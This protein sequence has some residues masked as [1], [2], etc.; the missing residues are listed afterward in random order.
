MLIC[1]IPPFT[2]WSVTKGKKSAEGRAGQETGQTW[3]PNPEERLKAY[4]FMDDPLPETHVGPATESW[5]G[6]R[7]LL[8]S[9]VSSRLPSRLLPSSDAISI[10]V[11]FK[12]CALG[13]GDDSSREYS[14]CCL[15]TSVSSWRVSQVTCSEIRTDGLVVP[16]VFLGASGDTLMSVSF[17]GPSVSGVVPCLLPS[18]VVVLV[19]TEFLVFHIQTPCVVLNML[20]D[21]GD[22]PSGVGTAALIE[23]SSLLLVPGTVVLAVLKVCL[24]LAEGVVF[25]VP[26]VGAVL[27]HSEPWPSRIWVAPEVH[28]LAAE[29]AVPGDAV[30][31]SLEAGA[32]A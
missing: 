20:L 19:V 16:V 6:V 3:G 23:P 1:S 12:A 29:D 10:H 11:A 14:I 25:L 30:M 8:S 13:A 22:G 31:G 9:V 7:G 32:A 24:P 28:L 17:R 27:S 15:D 26:V 21:F 2:D 18:L 4:L 5:L